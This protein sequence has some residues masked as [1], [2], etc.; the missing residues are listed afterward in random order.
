MGFLSGLC[1]SSV[2]LLAVAWPASGDEIRVF[3][4]AAV[5]LGD[6]VVRCGG[7][8]SAASETELAGATVPPDEASR[9][10]LPARAVTALAGRAAG[11]LP[12]G[13]AARAAAGV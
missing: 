2:S 3:V 8:D 10:P 5:L 13:L 12:G 6:D 4:G 9:G 11:R 7:S 1:E